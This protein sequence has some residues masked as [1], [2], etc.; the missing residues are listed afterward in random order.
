MELNTD[1]LSVLLKQQAKPILKEAFSEFLKE[2]NLAIFSAS[3]LDTT[4]LLSTS[5]V[6]KLVGVDRHTVY[7]YVNQGLPAIHSKPYKFRRCDVDDFI[8]KNLKSR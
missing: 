7:K 5:D 8:A 2:N 4:K 3:P 6:A 1:F